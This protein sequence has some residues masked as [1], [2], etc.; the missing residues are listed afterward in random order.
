MIG[1]FD[2][3]CS[4]W[5]EFVCGAI[6]TE[7]GDVNVYWSEVECFK[8][9]ADYEGTLWTWAG[10]RYDM[11]WL[12]SIAKLLAVR[13]EARMSGGQIVVLTI[14]KCTV[15]DG[16]KLYPVP[17]AVASEF[18]GIAKLE[19]GF[20]CI[21][22]EECGGYCRISRKMDST[23]RRR[24]EDYLVG[25]LKATAAVIQAIQDFADENDIV[26][27][28]TVGASA[29]ATLKAMGCPAAK[30]RTVRDYQF[31]RRGYY[32]GRTEIYQTRVVDFLYNYDINSA[33]PAALRDYAVPTGG[34]RR[35]TDS[36]SLLEL[37][38]GIFACT[39]LVPEMHVPPFPNRGVDR[40]LFVT[41]K[42]SGVWTGVEIQAAIAVGCRVLD[43]TEGIVW[44]R[45]EKVAAPFMEKFWGLR[46]KY[47]KKSPQGA[48]LKWFVNSLTGKLAMRPEGER[49]VGNPDIGE[50]KSC[51]G[52][53]KNWCLG[54]LC[55]THACCPHACL[56]TCGKWEAID[57]HAVIYSAPTFSLPDCGHVQFAATLTAHT[58]ID[59]G[60]H[61][62]HVDS[63]AVL[64]DTDSVKASQPSTY[65][66]GKEL[67]EWND[68]GLALDH[69]GPVPKA[70]RNAKATSKITKEQ[71]ETLA[72]QGLPGA[73]GDK[74]IDGSYDTR[75]KGVP[76]LDVLRFDRWASKQEGVALDRGVW[77]V[78]G[79]ARRGQ[80][81]ERR[82]IT[83]HVRSDGKTVGSRLVL[84]DGTTRPLSWAEYRASLTKER[85]NR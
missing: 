6:S 8:A 38:N 32:G 55:G 47:G 78:K 56:G 52:G 41:G 14:G 67:G 46:S 34:Y 7:K 27:K 13:V 59:L 26:L 42:Q 40:L 20:V 76:G 28:A 22:G 48:W 4:N 33:Y 44:E 69:W 11:V 60:S 49:L 3:E 53:R 16:F 5:D 45:S 35:F 17:L 63:D 65:R 10:G 77:G 39:V 24:L 61:L 84:D 74:V 71:A 83:R 25:D 75:A 54:A 73:E 1:A 30:W 2:I 23:E 50:I 15:R 12:Y 51:P 19:T 79:G 58:R 72:R 64:C 18:G 29:W 31:A 68:E 36:K 81:F 70:Y 57:S 82:N 43:V 37:S 80:V 62:R 85:V 66:I 21:C 9:V